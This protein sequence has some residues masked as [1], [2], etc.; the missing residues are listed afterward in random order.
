MPISFWCPLI[1]LAVLWGLCVL[2]GSIVAHKTSTKSAFYQ[3]IV[4]N[5]NNIFRNIFGIIGVLLAFYVWDWIAWIVIVLYGIF[6]LTTFIPFL[7]SFVLTLICMVRNRVPIHEWLTIL[8]NFY[9]CISDAVIILYCL[10]NI[11]LV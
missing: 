10:N 5:A 8:S 1:A 11:F 7:I 3:H 4:G 9:E 6:F 2:N